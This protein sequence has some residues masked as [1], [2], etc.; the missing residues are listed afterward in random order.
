MRDPSL[1][2]LGLHLAK[3]VL[4]L[5]HP[6]AHYPHRRHGDAGMALG[7]LRDPRPGPAEQ[8][9]VLDRFGSRRIG[10]SATDGD[11]ARD[12]AR[13]EIADNDMLSLGRRLA[14]L[15]A[16]GKDQ[17]ERLGRSTLPEKDLALS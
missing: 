11:A 13:A 6:A 14:D 3:P 16:P 4:Q 17:M 12:L 9:G 8:P 1:D 15:H 7:K 2:L 10:H 5:A